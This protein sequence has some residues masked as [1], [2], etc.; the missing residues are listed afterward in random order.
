[1]TVNTDPGADSPPPPADDRARPAG[2]GLIPAD[3]K[4]AGPAL[5]L[6]V[7]V[8]KAYGIA[9]YSLTTTAALV[10]ATP[11]AILIGTVALYAYVFVGLVAV[12]AAAVFAGGFIDAYR[13]RCRPLMPFSFALALIAVLLS[14]WHY[15]LDVVACALVVLLVYWILRLVRIRVALHS[16]AAA[17]VMLLLTV[18]VLATVR[19]AWL[20]AQV[21][22]LSQPIVGNPVHSV[23]SLTRKP[24]V[25]LVDDKDGWLTVLMDDDRFV[26]QVRD[27]TVVSRQVCH[28]NTQFPGAEPLFGVLTGQ[29]YV[30]HD[31]SCWRLT[32]QPDEQNLKTAPAIIRLLTWQF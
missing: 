18:F 24:V 23:T 16:F 21:I 11:L 30:P 13:E 14:P 10:A 6:A 3:I 32:D 26:A 28:L 22:T 2:R 31:V 8:A 15:T 4:L 25:Y 17:A 9:G 5:V 29:N 1:L 12:G 27:S 7:F 19:T 20:P